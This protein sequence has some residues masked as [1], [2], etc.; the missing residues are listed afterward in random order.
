[1][2]RHP[3]DVVKDKAKMLKVEEDF[4]SKH[5]DAI[6]E[7][8]AWIETFHEVIGTGQKYVLTP[9]YVLCPG[10]GKV[11]KLSEARNAYNLR[12]HLKKCKGKLHDIFLARLM[13][14]S[15]K[16]SAITFENEEF[17]VSEADK[18]EL[19]FEARYITGAQ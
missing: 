1:M 11:Q 5:P 19:P 16:K 18:F 12:A 17:D 10:C 4:Y 7:Y 13:K 3:N 9:L 14:W 2:H 6:D 8:H 15:D